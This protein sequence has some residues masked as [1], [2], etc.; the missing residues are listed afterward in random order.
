MEQFYEQKEHSSQSFSHDLS[1]GEDIG[2]KLLLQ[3]RY[4]SELMGGILPP[5]LEPSW[6]SRVLEIGWCVGGLAFEMA[7]RY[8]SLRITTIDRNAS[9]AE[10]TQALVRGL[11]NITIF[12]QDIHHL[13]DLEFA[14][15][16]FDL[17]LLR[18][19]AGN[20][21]REQLPPLMQSLARISRPRGL[22][23]WTEAEWP[24]TTSPACQQLCALVQQAL[25]A[26]GDAF[27]PGN[28][29]W[30][31]AHMDRW[32]SDA[33]YRIV[34]SK[35]YAIDISKGSNGHDAFVRQVWISREQLRAYL[36]ERGTLTAAE[37]EDVFVVM[38]QEIHEETFC[39]M[40]YLRTLVGVKF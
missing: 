9:V 16:S 1:D 6:G 14:S 32:L 19:L 33:G 17:I 13:D 4:L 11:G 34:Q 18:F 8:P 31:T 12:A 37:F 38:Q 30:V 36:L 25:Q 28:S 20:V 15:A 21:T 29:M 26:A 10:Q 24:V 23:V 39:G 35:T 2:A 22:L 3:H 7:F 40:V 5:L 27:A